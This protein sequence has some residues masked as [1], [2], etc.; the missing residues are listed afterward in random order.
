MRERSLVV[1][2]QILPRNDRVSRGINRNS[3]DPGKRTS[4][5]IVEALDNREKKIC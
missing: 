2:N 5:N 4:L 3:L 1:R